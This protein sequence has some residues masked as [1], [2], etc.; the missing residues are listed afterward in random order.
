MKRRMVI[1]N[2]LGVIFLVFQLLGYLGN[3]LHPEPKDVDF[4]ERLGGYVGFNFMLI[5]AVIFF[6]SARQL[7]KKINQQQI[8][9]DIDSIG[10]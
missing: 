8:D 1:Y 4:A 7:K 3:I 6:I 10:R 9:Q 2:V 5:L